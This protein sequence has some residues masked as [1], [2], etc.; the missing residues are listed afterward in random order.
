MNTKHDPFEDVELSQKE[1]LIEILAV[2]MV[3]LLLLAC[4][5]KVLFF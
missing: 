5:A 1:Q 3:A 2:G 4:I